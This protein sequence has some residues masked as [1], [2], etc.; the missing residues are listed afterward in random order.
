MAFSFSEHCS[1]RPNCLQLP[2][3]HLKIALQR[4]VVKEAFC[5]DDLQVLVLFSSILLLLLFHRK[6]NWMRHQGEGHEI[7]ESLDAI[8]TSPNCPE[9]LRLQLIITNNQGCS[10]ERQKQ[11]PIESAP[12]VSKRNS[13]GTDVIPSQ[14]LLLMRGF[15]SASVT[16]PETY[17]LDWQDNNDKIT[18]CILKVF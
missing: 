4:T 12:C 13:N 10:S 3:W 1:A 18:Q 8:C 9:I 17:C 16:D 11:C 14:H 7:L 6:R 5:K 15:Q 2:E